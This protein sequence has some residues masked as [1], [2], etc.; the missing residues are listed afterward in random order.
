MVPTNTVDVLQAAPFVRNPQVEQAAISPEVYPAEYSALLGYVDGSR[1][2][3]TYYHRVVGGSDHRTAPID[4]VSASHL[5]HTSYRQIHNFEMTLREGFAFSYDD[6]EGEGTTTGEA[7]TY[8][9]FRPEIGDLFLA[10]LGDGYV[11]EFK[12]TRAQPLSFRAQRVHLIGFV[13]NRLVGAP[14]MEELRLAAVQTLYFDK[15]TY[16]GDFKTLLTQEGYTHQQQLRRL[17]EVM[18]G[19]YLRQFYRA[20]GDSVFDLDGVYD[21]YLVQF[22]NRKLSFAST[23]RRPAQLYPRVEEGFAHT[24]WGRLVDPHYLSTAGLWRHAP[25]RRI[26]ETFR[27]VNIT[28]LLNQPCRVAQATAP[29]DDPAPYL[30][31][32]AFYDGVEAEMSA[33]ERLL[34]QA[35]TQR[36]VSNI[37][38]LLADHLHT[39]A[40]LEPAV[41]FHRVP[42]LIHLI[43]VAL[44]QVAGL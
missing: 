12:I 4:G 30:V 40:A 17:R 5:V 35:L 18:A 34:H 42:L 10:P 3:V 1:I 16:L 24:L 44:A 9:G 31:S 28:A 43:D 15:Q 36:R 11:G 38:G 21:P 6:G 25:S 37:G 19:H 32:A 20:G 26:T 13:R 29:S 22:L 27:A 14:E 8:P 39:F 23:G 2:T 7:V 41:A 33:F